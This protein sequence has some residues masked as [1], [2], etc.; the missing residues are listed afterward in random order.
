MR[1]SI[2]ENGYYYVRVIRDKKITQFSLKTKDPVLAQE[3]YLAYMKELIKC[4]LPTKSLVIA[5]V[6]NEKPI[7]K[8]LS[9]PDKTL[10]QVIIKP[11]FD[12]YLSLSKLKGFTKQTLNMKKQM[13]DTFL[14]FK[15]YTFEDINQENI[16]ELLTSLKKQ[17]RNDTVKK[18]VSE[19][20]AFLNYSIKQN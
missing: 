19:I 20:K 8:N 12:K 10:N 3:L 14:T 5:P 18:F 6:S 13:L 11:N 9:K 2:R 4:H 16:N 15:I 7:V 1:L 17:Y